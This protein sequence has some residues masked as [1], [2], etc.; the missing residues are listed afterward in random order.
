[1]KRYTAI[2][3]KLCTHHSGALALVVACLQCLH[4]ISKLHTKSVKMVSKRFS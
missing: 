4:F 1:M 2:V 3:L